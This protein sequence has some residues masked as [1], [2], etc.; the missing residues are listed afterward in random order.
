MRANLLG[1]GV[2]LFA[3]IE[4]YEDERGSFCEIFTERFAKGLYGRVK[5]VQE[6][7]SVSKPNVLRGL[8]YQ[9]KYPQGK[10]VRCV[11]GTILDVVVDIRLGSPEF[12][13]WKKVLL[14]SD[15]LESLWIPEGFAHG[16]YN[17]GNVPAKVMYQVTNYYSKENERTIRWDDKTL[18]IDWELLWNPIVSEKD[19]KGVSF[20]G[21]EYL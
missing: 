8:H 15:N 19:K 6:N 10:M 20:I 17:I 12:G 2:I 16:F 18:N 3:P 4:K 7:C 1:N 13:V 21:A 9:V 11:Q 14:N 5:F